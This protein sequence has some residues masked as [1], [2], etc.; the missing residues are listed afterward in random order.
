MHL[1]LTFYLAGKVLFALGWPEQD[2]AA[3]WDFAQS[4]QLEA[5]IQA[6]HSGQDPKLIEVRCIHLKQKPK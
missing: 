1:Y 6:T 3:C 4:T 5:R 2:A